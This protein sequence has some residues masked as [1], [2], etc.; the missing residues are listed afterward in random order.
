M[1][2][3]YHVSTFSWETEGITYWPHTVCWEE[4]KKVLISGMSYVKGDVHNP[5]TSHR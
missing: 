5:F 2:P 1:L 4:N 3:T